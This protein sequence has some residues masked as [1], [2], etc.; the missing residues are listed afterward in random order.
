MAINTSRIDLMAGMDEAVSNQRVR[1]YVSGDPVSTAAPGAQQYG[2][3]WMN[4]TGVATSFASGNQTYTAAQL[5]G[6]II[7]HNTGTT[8]T[9]G[10]TD[11]AANILAYMNVNSAGVN[12]GD[13]LQV[14]MLS[15]TG[16]TGTLTISGGTGITLDANGS[17]AVPVNGGSK[18]MLFR[19]TSTS[20][21]TFTLYM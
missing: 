14:A 7:I 16:T 11:T 2:T 13:I 8:A 5:G 18:Q 12:V 17:G 20:V 15:N 6:G 21:P 3:M 1:A 9:T 10:T 19:C 4:G